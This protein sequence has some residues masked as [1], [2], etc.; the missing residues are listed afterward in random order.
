MS[1]GWSRVTT[2]A[3]PSMLP[4]TATGAVS[5]VLSAVALNAAT[6]LPSGSCSFVP[7]VGSWYSIE[8]AAP[9]FTSPLNVRRASPSPVSELFSTTTAVTVSVLPL[10]VKREIAGVLDVSRSWSN[11]SVPR[12]RFTVA[13]RTIGVVSV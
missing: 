13:A 6:A 1:T 9:S 5:V 11:V 4:L 12:L 2:A 8:I 7:L 10:S 3:S